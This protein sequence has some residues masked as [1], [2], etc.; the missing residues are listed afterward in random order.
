MRAAGRLIRLHG[1]DDVHIVRVHVRDTDGRTGVGLTYTL[2]A[3]GTVVLA[4]VRDVLAPALE[5]VPLPQ[6][7]RTIEDVSRSTRRLGR[8]VLAPA[9]S[10]TDIAAWDLCGLVRDL[11]LFRLLGGRQ[12]TG[13]RSTAPAEGAT[14]WV[15]RSSWNSPWAMPSQA[16]ER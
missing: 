6:V 2:G 7:Q 15:T 14:S 13:C 11:P 4:M 8:A 3:G 1:A 12:E 5:G 10:A 9:V 16:S